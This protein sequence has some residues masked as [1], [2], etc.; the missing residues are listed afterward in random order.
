M[1][2]PLT[3]WIRGAFGGSPR[4]R[5]LRETLAT[6]DVTVQC[7]SLEERVVMDA[8]LPNLAN[9]NF[10][11]GQDLYVALPGTDSNNSPITYTAS[12]ANANV[13]ATILQG[14]RSISMTV[15]GKDVNGQDFSG[16]LTFRLF[17][18]LSPVTTARIITLVQ[19]GF[20]NGLDFHRILNGF[21]AQGGDPNGNGT[22]GS[23]VKI[24]DEFSK[25]LTFTSEGLLAMANSGDDTGDSQFFIT[26]DDLTLDSMPRS[27][28][29]NHTIFGILTSGFDTFNKIMTT[30]VQSNG[31][32]T[33]SP[34]TPV[35]MSNVQVFTDTT[36]GVL[37]ISAANGFT[38]SSTVTVSATGATGPAAVKNFIATG[39]SDTINDR[40]F[41]GPI[42]NISTAVNTPIS[43]TVTGIDL[44]SDN[45][46]FLVKDPTSASSNSSALSSATN[47]L[48]GTISIQTTQSNGTTPA[49]SLVTFTPDNG[50]IGSIDML[51]A[52]RD[53]TTH[54][55]SSGL[56]ARNN[57]DT[58][59]ITLTVTSTAT[60]VPPVANAGGPY[61][62]TEGGSLTV[63][64]AGT[65]DADNDT[66]T[67]SWDIN[68]DG[69]FGDATGV[70]PTLTKAQ[71]NALGINNGTAT[72]NIKVRVDDGHG[73]VVISDP[74]LF[75][76]TNAPP[77]ATITG[78]DTGA[79]GDVL[80]FTLGAT[81]PSTADQTAGF[82][83]KID[84]DGDGTFDQTVTGTSTQTVTHTF[85]KAGPVQVKVKAVDQD[86]GA[87]DVV[88]KQVNIQGIDLVNGTLNIV[89]DATDDVIKIIRDKKSGNVHLYMNYEDK[90]SFVVT[91]GI[92]IEG[93]AGN[94]RILIWSDV[95]PN[96]TIN[97]GDGNDEIKGGKGDDIIHGGAGNDSII[98]RDGDDQI[99]GGDGSNSLNGG[100]GN[101]LL[102]GGS[103]PDELRAG[104]GR[105]IVI[106]GQGADYITGDN[107]DML[108][109]SGTDFDTDEVSLGLIRDAWNSNLSLEDRITLL[110]ETGVGPDAD[111]LI[112]N[113]SAAPTVNDDSA[114]DQ[115]FSSGK[116][117]MV[118]FSNDGLFD[119]TKTA[120][121]GIGDATA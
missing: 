81:D 95:A 67:Y 66:L 75:T 91:N 11:G 55:N 22:G 32:E 40:P 13:S 48:H 73:H 113:F 105:D 100:G 79:K 6:H 82:T 108:I 51:I 64:A 2:N 102:V 19:Q 42:Q 114:R 49:T 3:N 63:T 53:S 120:I 29:F 89:G 121:K 56:D 77:V 92:K 54:A 5:N 28:N 112:D 62:V 7:E 110:S 34:V 71:L 70:N 30:P 94:D 52:V 88:T 21:V 57:Y 107:G 20:Y 25:G 12:S 24:D 87:S 16:T 8:S 96:A 45:L 85:T 98:G 14:G 80:T 26:D 38:G 86:G 23:G 33:S 76:F 61:T 117:W 74:T 118:G 90:G 18:D 27:L 44:E 104:T 93:G 69:T 115:I 36:H 4:K 46:T 60:N 103:S 78:P 101:D 109:G 99:F 68:G 37:K 84:W 15:S 47:P 31:S 119:T 59:K 41:L 17:E 106:G 111:I 39:V 97:G 83:W 116:T 50:F 9:A 65:T 72:F 1:N 10:I 43:F 58:Q 35:V